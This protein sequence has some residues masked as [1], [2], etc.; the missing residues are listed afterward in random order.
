MTR[1]TRRQVVATAAAAAVCSGALLSACG[2]GQQGSAQTTHMTTPAKSNEI[3]APKWP[4]NKPKPKPKPKPAP[5]PAAA[6]AAVPTTT[7]NRWYPLDPGIQ[8]VRE[9]GVNVG[10]RRLPHRLVTTVTNVHK[11]IDGVKTVAVL[12]QD[13]N[14]GE[15]TEQSLDFFHTS[16]NGDVRYYGTYTEHFEGGQFVFASDAWLSGTNGAQVGTW[17]PGHPRAGT[18]AY[19]EENVPGIP[20]S[21][22]QVIKTGLHHCVPFKCYDGVVIVQ[23]DFEYKYYAPGVGHIETSPQSGAKQ[24][25]EQ[26]ANFTRLTGQGLGQANREA[27]KMDR[28]ARSQRSDVFGGSHPAKLG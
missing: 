12:D 4:K 8:S 27:L 6:P 16:K 7:G 28:R 2:G 11:V 17:I 14:G 13:I 23:E 5:K 22:G 15:I 20:Q 10:H 18:P 3:P 26:L 1:K 21:T 19:Y 24:E 9:G 25:T